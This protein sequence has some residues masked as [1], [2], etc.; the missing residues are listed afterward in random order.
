MLT[1]KRVLVGVTGGIAAY[2]AAELV[3]SLRESGA[4]VNVVLTEAAREFVQPLT[5]KALSGNQVYTGLFGGL[6][7]VPHIS[8]AKESDL[9]V[10]YPATANFIG[11]AANGL[12]PDLLTT[13]VLA[14]KGPVVICPSMN[15]RMFANV[16]VQHNLARLQDYGYVIVPPE[17]G[18]LACGEV[19]QGRLP[20]PGAVLEVIRG[21]L[22]PKDL[23]G[24]NFLVTAGPTR[25]PLDP[26]RYI[27]NRSSGK[28][29]YALARAARDRGAQV[30]LIS[31]PTSLAKPAGVSYSG[32][33]TA[34]EMREAVLENFDAADVVIMCAAVSDY[35]AKT[36]SPKKVKK[37]V[38]EMVLE[39]VQNP[40]ILEELG[41][42]KRHQLLIGFA[43][44]DDNILEHARR[45]LEAKN[46]DM[47]VANLIAQEGAGFE[48]DTN[49]VKILFRNGRF[50]ELPRM[51]KYEVAQRLMDMVLDMRRI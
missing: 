45:K 31:G 51:D 30:V 11:H 50:L 36:P 46:L 5:F 17:S 2:K 9:V 18:R 34:L 49:I 26:V 22:V 10:V 37:E 15:A 6:D 4:T 14:F 29:G 13:L 47:V 42:L 21:A 40:D 32:V 33:K 41:R 39:F 27:S 35:R 16:A 1:K 48:A 3:S 28:M 38:R 19:G 24:L 44:E 25:E 23:K 7:P 8:A 43:A 20:A 12:A